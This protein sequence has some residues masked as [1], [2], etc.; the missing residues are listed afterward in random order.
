MSVVPPE[1]Q[2]KIASWRHRAATGEL[3]QEEMKEAIV[4]LRAGRL[5]AAKASQAARTKRAKA[6]IPNA[7]ALLGEM[8]G[9]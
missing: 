5:E 6:E 2:S 8:E 4:W 3:T 1:L 9:L 7:S